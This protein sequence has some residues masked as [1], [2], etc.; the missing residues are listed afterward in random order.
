MQPCAT[1]RA[2][3]RQPPMGAEVTLEKLEA[4]KGWNAP[5]L[6]LARSLARCRLK[7]RLRARTRLYGR[8]RQHPLH[9]DAGRTLPW[10]AVHGDRRA[11]APFQRPWAERVS[12]PAHRAAG[13]AGGGEG[14]RRSLDALDAWDPASSAK[15]IWAA[16]LGW[17]WVAQKSGFFSMAVTSHLASGFLAWDRHRCRW[18]AGCRSDL[19]WLDHPDAAQRHHRFHPRRHRL[20][21]LFDHCAPAQRPP[22]VAARAVKCRQDRHLS[23]QDRRGRRPPYMLVA[24]TSMQ[25]APVAH[26]GVL[27]P[28][29][30]PLFVALYSLTAL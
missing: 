26:V 15:R 12:P 19:G 16:S 18:R 9:G 25:F 3:Q 1:S 10:G 2:A 27:M 29:T 20:P 28:G 6:P 13:D 14:P 24:A 7:G 30:M 17:R 11:R 22:L 23:H 21:A 4:S 8:G 5:S